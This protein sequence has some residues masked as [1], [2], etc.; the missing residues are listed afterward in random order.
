MKRFTPRQQTQLVTLG[1]NSQVNIEKGRRQCKSL[2]HMFVH[3]AQRCLLRSNLV[4]SLTPGQDIGELNMFMVL[5]S[6]F[7]LV[8]NEIET[9]LLTRR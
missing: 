7:S 1:Y 2:A 8:S 6:L 5:V 4:R 9:Q 3:A